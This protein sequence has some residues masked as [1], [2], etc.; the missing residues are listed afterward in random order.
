MLWNVLVFALIVYL[1]ICLFFWIAQRSFIYMPRPETAD[2]AGAVNLQLPDVTL[3]I[4]QQPHDGP[5]ALVYL[6]GNAEDVAFTVPE[7]AAAF[8][9]RAIYGLHYRGYC[10]SSG[11]PTEA[12]LRHDART[13]FD[14]VHAQHDDIMVV[15]RSLGSSLAVQ[16][17]AERP[18]SRL[19]LIAPFA[20]ILRIA[21]RVAPFIPMRL[22]L[23]DKYESWRFA[24]G[25][26]CPTL[27]LAASDD[28][29][30]PMA[31]TMELFD[32]FAPGVAQLRII[33]GADH[34]SLSDTTEFWDAL[35]NGR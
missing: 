14:M 34:N 35:I 18:V 21:S 10:G 24:P 6:G 1:G 17:A 11:R 31:D 4:S 7:L 16:L 3:R 12:G 28:E 5:L 22:L 27:I 2:H 29:L 25:V 32:G 33:D 9:D 13:V 23:H 26:R 15:G 20:S 19:V 30:V 8:P